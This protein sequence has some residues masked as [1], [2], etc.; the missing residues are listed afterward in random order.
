MI[1]RDNDIT[2][3]L[4]ADFLEGTLSQEE[5]EQVRKAME[6]AEAAKAEYAWLARAAEDFHAISENIVRDAPEIDV[7]DG[8]MQ[9]VQKVDESA[10][11]VERQHV[12]KP[13]PSFA[14]WGGLALAAAVVLI[15]AG[16]VFEWGVFAPVQPVGPPVAQRP[17]TH[18][19]PDESMV[20]VIPPAESEPDS[21]GNAMQQLAHN[22]TQK[23]DASAKHGN[24][25][26][27]LATAAP[28]VSKVTQDEVVSL[29]QAA[30]T[31][32][33]AWGRLHR[34]AT[35]DAET[36]EKVLANPDATPDAIVGV[37]AS[38]PDEEA[39][40]WLVTAV[41]RMDQ[42]KPYARLAL[43]E[44][45]VPDPVSTTKSAEEPPTLFDGM[46]AEDLQAFLGEIAALQEAD[47]QNALFD[48][49]RA[50]A[51]FRMGDAEAA[52]AALESLRGKEFATAYGLEA[53][54]SRQEALT[55]A[56]MSE[57]A[58]QML[59][60]VLAG[61]DE[62]NMLCSLA[63]ELLET[64]QAYEDQ[65]DTDV[66][67]QVYEATQQLGEQVSDGA[68][69]SEEALAGVDIQRMAL[70]E[71]EGLHA[72]GNF[73]GDLGRLT[74]SAV[75]LVQQINDLGQVLGILDQQFMSAGDS[76]FWGEL[77]E[78][79]LELGDLML[80]QAMPE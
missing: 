52:L 70:E 59:S 53:A 72:S 17:D 19:Q 39:R 44:T 34:M 30:I 36:A 20:A 33:Q 13:R 66:A 38:L 23:L 61:S 60:A 80:F 11:I 79:I 29:R 21:F 18:E 71:L 24:Q 69:L 6:A 16:L 37:A 4:L 26:E 48:A 7:L 35:L 49:L 1:D 27:F 63:R 50:G 10:R 74:N 3:D 25:H 56:G 65:G 73:V 64:G 57:E 54:R 77:S 51:L 31:D 68:L 67:Q 15:I 46:S 76:A 75:Q 8:V 42:Q 43:A 45:Y 9:A 5:A 47:P 55:A 22:V 28:N 32:P 62:Y 78:Q 12:R 40:Q 14:L 2:L 58:A 41:G